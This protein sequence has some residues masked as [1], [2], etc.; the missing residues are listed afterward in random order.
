MVK[1]N[2]VILLRNIEHVRVVSLGLFARHFY[3]FIIV[4]VESFKEPSVV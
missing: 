4:Q 1:T 2:V 3:S